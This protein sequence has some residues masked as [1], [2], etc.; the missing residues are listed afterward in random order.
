MRTIF[1][2]S[3]FQILAFNDYFLVY[4]KFKLLFDD[5][6]LFR[7]NYLWTIKNQPIMSEEMITSL[8][9]HESYDKYSNLQLGIWK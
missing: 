6:M 1:I 3:F 2:S 7:E 5:Q 8:F 9:C 4:L